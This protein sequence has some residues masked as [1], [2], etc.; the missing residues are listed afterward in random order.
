MRPRWKHYIVYGLFD[1]VAGE[2]RYIG[3]SE[4][5]RQRFRKHIVSSGTSDLPSARWIASL[6]RRGLSPEF[7]ILR[8]CSGRDEL[9][10]AECELIA[11]AR[12]DGK[13]LLNVTDGGDGWHGCRHTDLSKAKIAR[14][15]K[16]SERD[17]VM[18]MAIRGDKGAQER[19][20]A[21]LRKR[22]GVNDRVAVAKGEVFNGSPFTCH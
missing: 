14:A 20:R 3:K 2:L 19:I 6:L 1:P 11:A 21:D 16:S 15:H 9:I 7:R 18:C 10:A 4:S 22:T 8:E 5:G 12:S 13:R 17:C